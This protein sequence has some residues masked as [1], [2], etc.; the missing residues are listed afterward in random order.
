MLASASHS[1]SAYGLGISSFIP[2]P[3]LVTSRRPPDVAIRRGRVRETEF[4]STFDE[5]QVIL[6]PELNLSVRSGES[7]F[8]IE[9]KNLGRCL[10]RK[11]REII[12]EPD[13]GVD[14]MELVPYITGP[15]LAVLLHQRDLL[16]LHA[17]AAAFGNS[18]AVIL[19][20]KGYG[21][22]TQAAHLEMRSHP[23]ISDDLVPVS[24]KGGQPATFA[25]CPQIKLYDD[26]LESIGL[27]AANVPLVTPNHPKRYLKCEDHF[28]DRPLN[29]GSVF[30]LENSPKI[31]LVRLSA[32]AAFIGIAHNSYMGGYL[33]E[34]NSVAA[35]FRQCQALVNSTPIFRLRRPHDFGCIAEVTDLIERT[36]SDLAVN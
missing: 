5:D 36:M 12:I 17:S 10:V 16:V 28:A 24:F 25:G 30:I 35:H 31:D 19:G 21:K 9:W 20:H 8:C 13:R 7:A 26:S 32:T 34:T 18:A 29:I 15:G 33:A 4:F 11:Q 6:K 2:L 3:G 14:T 27:G 22:S 23:L 1:Y